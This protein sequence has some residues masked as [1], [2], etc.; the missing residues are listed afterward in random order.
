[1]PEENEKA[2]VFSPE[3]MDNNARNIVLEA[4]EN[5]TGLTPRFNSYSVV[6]KYD[7]WPLKSCITAILPNG[8]E[9]GYIIFIQTFNNF[10]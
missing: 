2:I 7:D 10:F 6:L 5:L 8:L 9:F 4:I 3:K 1:M